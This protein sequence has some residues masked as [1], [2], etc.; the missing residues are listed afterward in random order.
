MESYYIDLK[1]I[2][3]L[4]HNQTSRRMVFFKLKVPAF[5]TV[6]IYKIPCSLSPEECENANIKLSQH[7][8]SEVNSSELLLKNDKVQANFSNGYW[9]SYE[10]F[11][12]KITQSVQEN[13]TYYSTDFFSK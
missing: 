8:K 7:V 2:D 4:S 6:N 3:T 5:G 13:I 12:N 9:T 10:S 11:G 1:Q